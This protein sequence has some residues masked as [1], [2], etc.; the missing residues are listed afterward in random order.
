M[1]S[2]SGSVEGLECVSGGHI[3]KAFFRATFGVGVRRGGNWR[4]AMEGALRTS[5]A[6]RAQ[7]SRD[8][9]ALPS[10]F[11]FVGFRKRM[12]V[13]KARQEGP[14]CQGTR[15][16]ENLSL[17]HRFWNFPQLTFQLNIQKAQAFSRPVN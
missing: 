8:Q 16:N 9:T 13:L 2:S 11:G 10:G 14:S 3:K 15:V 12:G 5:H 6:A 17:G 1:S 7:G 4:P